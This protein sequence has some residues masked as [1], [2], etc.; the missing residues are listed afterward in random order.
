VR[1]ILLFFM[2]LG[3]V[4]PVRA[5]TPVHGLSLLGAPQ[6]PANFTHFPYVNPDAPKGG[7]LV[8]S[9]VGSF[10]SFHP[11]IVRGSPAT[12]VNRIYD[13]LMRPNEDEP[14]GYYGH[15]AG[16]I[17]VWPENRG[18]TFVLRPEARFNDGS[19]V[20][21][22][23]VVWTFNAL[24]EQGR[25]RYRQYYADVSEAIIEAPDRVGFR[26]KTT[27]NRELPLILGQLPVLP[28]AWW[29]GRDFSKPLTEP[30]LG[31]GPYRVAEFELGRTV[32]LARVPDYW[33]KDLPTGKGLANFDRIRTEYFRDDT[34]ALQ[35]LKAGQVDFRQ[36]SSSKT[37]ATA[38]DFPAVE[39]G[40]VKKE[41]LP[42]RLPTGMQGFFMNTRR[43]VFQ[44]ARVRQALA[45][46]FDFEW[47][48]AN[49]FYGAYARTTSYFSNS[50]LAATGL[51]SAA[52]L[53]LLEPFRAQLPPGLFTEEFKLPVSDAS[54]NN[55]AALRQ[56]LGFL[57]AAGWE[58][59]DLKLVNA[60]GVQMS[61]EILLSQPSMERVALPYVQ[62]LARM[63]IDA[64]VRTVDP[65][66]YQRLS[67]SYDFDMTDGLISESDSPGNEQTGFW[68]CDA[69]KL[70]GSDNIAGVC[71]PAV[72][73]II[74]HILAAPDRAALVTATHALDR[75][76]LW[77]WYAVPHWYNRAIWVVHWDRF[78]HPQKPVRVGLALDSWWFDASRA[79]VTDA[80]RVAGK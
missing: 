3:L 67:D 47:V 34:I 44:D 9:A 39:K 12:S 62:W 58:I 14:E 41:A 60:A 74:K 17:I 54:G 23:D 27:T 13:T 69:A 8:L 43:P 51:P 45:W 55:R 76:L 65:A 26:F 75:V 5:Q 79:I 31:S 72:E 59:K 33:A 80:A 49:L 53:A 16:S 21:A 36:E 57:K 40:L 37:W 56:A 50:D 18:V 64:R 24:R 68:G 2:L 7:D 28:K 71:H 29:N 1:P 25:P 32:T 35:A 38:Y 11:F 63:G 70:A 19:K 4:G 30:P 78:D 10:D 61:F 52:E 15:L 6:L 46:V 22:D 48:N 20:T 77:N 73:A 66:Q 42:H